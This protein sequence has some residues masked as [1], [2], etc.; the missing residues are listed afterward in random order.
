[1]TPAAKAMNLAPYT[2]PDP[3]D[4]TGLPTYAD[5]NP[6]AQ[7]T[8]GNPEPEVLPCVE[9]IT[10]PYTLGTF[11]RISM[12]F[13]RLTQNMSPGQVQGIEAAPKQYI[14][15]LPHGTGRSFYQ[16]RPHANREAKAFIES[17]DLD[18]DGIDIALPIAHHPGKKP[19]DFDGPW[20]MIL[21]G[22]SPELRD[23]LLWYQTFAVNENVT[24]HAI[25]FNLD[26]EDWVIMTISG[27]AVH[28]DARSIAKALGSIKRRLWADTTFVNFVNA[29]FAQAGIG[30]SACERVVEAT[31]SFQLTY[32]D[33][34]NAKGDHAPVYQLTGKPISKEPETHRRWLSLIR[35][36]RG[37]YVVGMHALVIDKR[38]VDCVWCKSKMH[39]AHGCPFHGVDGWLGT[40]P[41]NVQRY[42]DRTHNQQKDEGHR[43]DGGHK[44]NNKGKGRQE[45]NRSDG[46][47][48]V[49]RGGRHNRYTM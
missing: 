6:N 5:Q 30:G 4:M 25:A 37:G 10:V 38:F 28:P 16:R 8:K 42:L 9:R 45:G 32:I 19:R 35:G 29:V 24:F 43:V 12:P 15:L 14:A 44:A 49:G 36:L 17:F 40:K 48:T 11:P 23:F 3:E 46:W 20:P 33:T 2:M 22:A 27:D 26:A 47:S 18:T 21:S 34:G 1:M 13:P 7:M 39:P 41:D 31:K